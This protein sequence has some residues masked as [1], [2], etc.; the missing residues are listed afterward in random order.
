W[1]AMMD[2]ER[3]LVDWPVAGKRMPDCRPGFSL[4]YIGLSQ[5]Q[6]CQGKPW[7]TGSQSYLVLAVRAAPKADARHGQYVDL[8]NPCTTEVFIAMTHQKTFEQLK[9]G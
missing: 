8:L 3:W 2:Q 9:R 5:P 1:R 4:A 7:P 6:N